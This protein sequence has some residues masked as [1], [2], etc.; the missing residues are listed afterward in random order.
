MKPQVI[1]I[2]GASSGIGAAL[3]I[4]YADASSLLVLLGR[5]KARL[6]EV[7]QE[8]EKKGAKVITAI[9]NVNDADAMK[10]FM[11]KMDH[12]HPID[13][14][15]ANAGIS[16]G[17]GGL[18]EGIAQVNQI[19]DINVRGVLNTIWP[20]IPRMQQRQSGQ[21]ALMASLAGFRGFPGAPAYCASKA[22]V[23]VYGEALRGDLAKF[24]IKI[25]V[26]CPGYVKSRM[27]EVNDFPM[28]FL[29][30]AE[31]AAK[32][33]VHALQKNRP[34]I[35]FPWPTYICAWILGFLPPA[36]TDRLLGSL[37]QKTGDLP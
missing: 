20:L 9:I 15:I 33:I 19:L 25:N 17:T 24:G 21:I 1:L 23:K 14:V 22:Y 16:G 7:K 36:L 34:R 8:C 35:A 37:P 11:E 18:G 4:A 28:P 27:T 5:N 32:I 30:P 2:T 29:M 3:A 10:D 12:Q 26:I 31:K 6:Q 13:L